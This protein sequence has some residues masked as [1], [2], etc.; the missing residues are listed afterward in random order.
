MEKRRRELL[1][2]A[3]ASA[4]VLAVVP[5]TAAAADDAQGLSEIRNELRALRETLRVPPGEVQRIRMVQNTFLRSTGKFPDVIEVGTHY[6]EVVHDWLRESPQP[7]DV[8]QLA[9]GRYGLRFGF[10]M[11]MLRP[12]A[13]A[14]FLGTAQE[15]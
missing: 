1:T 8:T 15:R 13:P 11:L 7:V 6:W 9:N 2:T 3:L 4:G 14:D 12:D 10:T 5:Q